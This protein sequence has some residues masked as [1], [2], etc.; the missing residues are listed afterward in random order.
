MLYDNHSIQIQISK[1][2]NVNQEY[3]ISLIILILKEYLCPNPKKHVILSL[4]L[5]HLIWY[6]TNL[7]T[8]FFHILLIKI[9]IIY[10]LIQVF[11]I[12]KVCIFQLTINF[13]LFIISLIFLKAILHFYLIFSLLIWSNTFQEFRNIMIN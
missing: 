6:I 7:I 8:L 10:S 3:S 2:I 5:Y 1:T 13:T 12:L 9:P 4:V 11:L